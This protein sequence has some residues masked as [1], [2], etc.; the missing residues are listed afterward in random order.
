MNSELIAVLDAFKALCDS[1]G[2]REIKSEQEL[3][4]KLRVL[5][6][7]LGM[8]LDKE[9]IFPEKPVQG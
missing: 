5:K 1:W 4:D 6:T 2:L 7:R 9:S 3:I 8:E